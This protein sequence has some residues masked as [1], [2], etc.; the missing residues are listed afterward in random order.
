MIE[1]ISPFIAVILS[2]LIAYLFK[3]V[4]TDQIKLL[5]SFSGAFLLAVTIFEFLPSVYTSQHPHIGIAIMSGIMVQITLEFVSKGAEH[6]HV[7]VKTQQ[8]FPWLLAIGLCIHAFFEGLPLSETQ[9]LLYAVVVHK[10]PIT[11]IIT[12]FLFGSQISKRRTILFL[13]LFAIMTPLGTLLYND[14]SILTTHKTIIHAFVIGILLHVSTT[15]L[16]ESSKNHQFNAS[17]LAVILLGIFIAYF[18]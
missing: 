9:N 3:H 8:H 15:I 11:I 1:I 12:I 10:I 16:F 5:L 13:T 2:A 7:H 4:I 17:K 18:I 6:G 14:L